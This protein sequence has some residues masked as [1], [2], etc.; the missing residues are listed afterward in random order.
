[1]AKVLRLVLALLAALVTAAP[2][3]AA[4]PVWVIRDA[5]S[6][7][8]LFG[9]VHILPH[10]ID[11]APKTLTDSLAQA[12][13]LWF[14]IPPDETTAAEVSLL[15]ARHAQLP[16]GKTLSSLLDAKSRARL[17]RVAADVGLPVAA[18][19]QMQPWMAE[20]QLMVAFLYRRGGL[21]A[22]GVEEKISAMAPPGVQRRAFETAD[23]QVGILAGGDMTTQVASLKETLR[24]LSEDPAS[25]DRMI[26]AW[27]SG[28]VKALSREAVEPLRKAAPQSYEAL[29]V[30]RNRA[31]TEIIAKRLAGSGRTVMV[32]GA[33]HLVGPD[34]VPALLRARGVAVEGP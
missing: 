23:Q 30:Q 17:R 8:V 20:V 25:F 14:E 4:A 24:E 29:V 34:S 19:D 28:D 12:D 22:E 26:K 9:S 16:P 3:R 1:M 7:I 10:G 27:A 6:T 32:V 33:G 18:L 11:W 15:A 13:D 5:D 21:M 31:W 2:A